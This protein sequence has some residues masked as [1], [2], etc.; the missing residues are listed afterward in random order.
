M[1]GVALMTSVAAI[2]AGI[3]WAK[4]R[5][6]ARAGAVEAAHL[7][8]LVKKRVERPNVFSHEVRT[9]LTLIAG[10]AELLAEESPGPLTARQREFV[11]TIR[12]NAHQVIG[13]AEDLLAEARLDAQLF[14]LRPEDVDLR[15][16][17]R[18]IVRDVRRIHPNAV[19][20][21]NHGAP[22]RVR[23]DRSLLRQ[24]LWNLVNNACRHAG[25]SAEITLS[26]THGEGQ[27]IVAV[28]DDGVGLSPEDRVSLFEPFVVGSAQEGGTGLGMVITE[29][30][31]EQHG[32]HLLVD[33]IPGRG[34]TIFFV[35]PTAEEVAAHG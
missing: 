33:S 19:R 15:V 5:R 17:V 2:V 3:Q 23:A 30:I 27:G 12:V 34:T 24:A 1:W 11:E 35:L 14:E 20:L 13:L 26:V 25:Q 31:I 7:R 21:D 32:G 22:V 4:A 28:S 29:R 8:D 18:D 6:E 9:P 16:L 10:A